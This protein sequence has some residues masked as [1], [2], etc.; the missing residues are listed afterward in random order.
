MSTSLGLSHESACRKARPRA[1]VLG[2]M[3][4]TVAWESHTTMLRPFSVS[5]LRAP[6]ALR[7]RLRA[8]EPVGRWVADIADR[9]GGPTAASAG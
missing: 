9:V 3:L 4:L 5:F 6:K 2:V 1:G 8:G 7:S